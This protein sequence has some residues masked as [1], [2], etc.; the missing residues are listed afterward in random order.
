MEKIRSDMPFLFRLP[1]FDFDIEDPATLEKHRD[2]ILAAIKG[3]SLVLHGEL[4]GKPFAD[5]EEKLRL[6]LRKYLLRGR[7]RPTPFGSFAGVGLA[8]WGRQLK[9][10]FPIRAVELKDW[11]TANPAS[12]NAK[13]VTPLASTY[14]LVPGIHQK[15][16]Y[17]QALV[18]DSQTQR[19][20]GCKLPENRLFAT[21]IKE[22]SNKGIKFSEFRLLLNPKESG[23]TQNQAL[24]AQQIWDQLI[25]LGF[26][27]RKANPKP[28]K[29]GMDM[30]LKNQPEIPETINGQLQHFVNSAGNLFSREESNYLRNFKDWFI[31]QYDDRYVKLNELLT[32]G[33]FFSGSFHFQDDPQQSEP[34]IAAT[35]LAG[36]GKKWIDLEKELPKA[37]LP[38]GIHDIQILYRLDKNLNPVIENIVCNR[39]FVYTGRFNRDPEIKAYSKKIRDQ[40]HTDPHI[41]FAH[42][43]IRETDAINHICNATSIFDHE[44]S[45]SPPHSRKQ[46]DFGDLYMGIEGNRLILIHR[47]S[48]KPVIPVVMHPLNG[49]QITHPILRLL[50]EIAHQDRYRFIPYQSPELSQAQVCPQLNWGNLCLQSRRW[51]LSSETARDSQ[52]LSKRLDEWDVPQHILAGNMDRELLLD[53]HHPDD[54][55][56]LAQELKRNGKL[57]LSTPNW[58]PSFQFHYQTG[59]AVYPQFVFRYSRPLSIPQ[60]RANFNPITHSQ[61]DCLCLI[62]T[63]SQSE[64]AEVLE[65][66]FQ[67]MEE[68]KIQFGI[69]AWFFLVYG[70]NRSTEIRLRLL[71]ITA[72][73]QKTLLLKFSLIFTEE[74]WNWKTASYYPETFKY[75]R[76]S[77]TRSHRLFHLESQF[78]SEKTAGEM[79]L[80]YPTDWKENIV[81]RLWRQLV[82]QCP[83]PSRFFTS[84]KENVK[85][86]PSELLIRYKSGFSY[87]DPEEPSPFPTEPYLHTIISHPSFYDTGEVATNFLHNHIHLMVNRFFPQDTAYHERKI[88]Y[89]LYRELGKHLY[90]RQPPLS[91]CIPKQE[92]VSDSLYPGEPDR[93]AFQAQT[94]KL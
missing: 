43:E 19:W 75:G 17:F 77:I 68:E 10:D 27:T 25:D 2:T 22:A 86:M 54:L 71:E 88:L 62:L 40:I 91:G 81:V 34:D 8:R 30:V 57:S 38:G 13:P 53:R 33:E 36:N 24:Q 35:V 44:I 21:L 31:H 39:P 47:P 61:K 41:L 58:Y 79:H 56:I 15:N 12:Q 4:E 42:L 52:T 55:K 29:T 82:F 85:Q 20:T 18:L 69:P 5:L 26:L 94:Q 51:N 73:H 32:Q 49:N 80:N 93:Q 74:N 60:I 6:K 16:G 1:L 46:L 70:K 76:K 50:W 72:E 14:Q 83:N 7:F 63:C 65:R 3:S 90:T 45:S 23:I 48:G 67:R 37:E 64:V 84:L 89:R 66:L 78:L 9:T 87:L 59:T 11:K 28:A 92:L